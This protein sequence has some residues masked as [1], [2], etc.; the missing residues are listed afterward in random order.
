MAIRIMMVDNDNNHMDAVKQYFSSSS[1]ISVVKTFSD[2]KEA[3]N[4]LDSDYDVLIVNMLL[5]GVNG[6]MIL[7]KYKELGLSKLVIVTS[8]YISPEMMASIGEFK[9]NYIIKKPFTPDALETIVNKVINN[10]SGVGSNL[11][12]E[13][14]DLL[15]SL[16]I[17]SHIKGYTY[18]RDGIE[19]MFEDNSLVGSITKELYPTIAEHYSTTSSRVERAIRHAIEVS[20]VR[21]D[22]ALMEE[23]FGNSV[24]YDR[25]KPTNSEFLATLADRLKL[26]KEIA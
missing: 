25:A 8:E 17:P 21:G 23:I 4:N 9:P 22:Y 1:S 24:D 3:I 7:D 6:E 13:I 20:W 12:I 5:S 19:M 10:R 15:H 26:Q 2:G 11:R 14:T 16:G 18:I